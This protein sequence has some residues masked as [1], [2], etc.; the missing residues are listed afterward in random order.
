MKGSYIIQIN[1]DNFKQKLQEYEM[2]KSL[3]HPNIL[4]YIFFIQGKGKY[5]QMSKIVKEFIEGKTMSTY[6]KDVGHPKLTQI[7][8]VKEIGE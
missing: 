6:I 4:K 5:S 2:A 1:T 8:Y 3:D 7:P